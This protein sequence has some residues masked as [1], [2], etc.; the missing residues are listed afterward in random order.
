MALTA[1]QKARLAEFSV[2]QDANK[3]STPTPAPTPTATT[4]QTTKPSIT[5]QIKQRNTAVVPLN[6]TAQTQA[7]LKQPKPA[8]QA[9]SRLPYVT[10]K[11]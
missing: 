3:T 9:P 4:T 5:E 10:T 8:I 2:Q 6:I 7:S 1:Q 11:Q